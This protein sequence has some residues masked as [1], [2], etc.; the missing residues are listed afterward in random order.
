MSL[1]QY[2]HPLRDKKTALIAAMFDSI[3]ARYDF[4]NTVLSLG[5]H[6]LWRRHLLALLKPHTDQAVLDLCCGSGA[7]YWKMVAGRKNNQGG[8]PLVC[9]MDI[10]KEMLKHAK[11]RDRSVNQS[12]FVQAD[13]ERIPVMNQSFG[14]ITV[15]FGLRNVFN[16]DAVLSEIRRVLRPAGCLLVL[17]FGSLNGSLWSRFFNFYAGNVLPLLG[18]I[19]TG[20]SEAYRYLHDS[21]QSFPAGQRFLDVLERSGFVRCGYR[22]LLGGVAHLYWASRED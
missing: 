18:G 11:Y 2:S 7:L 9:G 20:N 5:L 19:I 8:V 12:N 22:K 21:I 10:S 13:I 3:A 16:L 1:S 15:G 17:E 14:V 6:L 4:A